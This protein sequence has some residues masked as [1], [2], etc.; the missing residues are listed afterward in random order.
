[1]SHFLTLSGVTTTYLQIRHHLPFCGS[2][3][4]L[5]APLRASSL[6][7]TPTLLN[8]TFT[9]SEN[10][11]CM[12]RVVSSTSASSGMTARCRSA[13]PCIV[14]SFTFS[15]ACAVTYIVT[16]TNIQ[17]DLFHFDFRLSKHLINFNIPAVLGTLHVTVTVVMPLS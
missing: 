3:A 13:S 14:V 10:I 16:L 9:V 1:M 11:T 17:I 15:Y 2:A 12:S 5:L 6:S 4:D 7:F 8:E